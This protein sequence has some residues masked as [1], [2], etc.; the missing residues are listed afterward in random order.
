MALQGI[1]TGTA[2][3]DGKGDSLLAGALKVNANFV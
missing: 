1:T 3:N 2:P